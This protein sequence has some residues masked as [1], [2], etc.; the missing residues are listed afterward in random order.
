MYL[1]CKLD[2]FIRHDNAHALRE[3]VNRML[4]LLEHKMTIEC[5]NWTTDTS[6]RQD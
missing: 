3:N 4:C 2:M 5:V 6:M 1:G